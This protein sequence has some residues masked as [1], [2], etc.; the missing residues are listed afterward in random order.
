M[1]KTSIISLRKIKKIYKL[2]EREI[3]VL[4]DID[5]EV[6]KGE[7]LAIMGCLRFR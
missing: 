7:F 4:K 3:E 2:G 1:S 6:E 5:L